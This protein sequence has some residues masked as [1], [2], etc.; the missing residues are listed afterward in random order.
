MKE[1]ILYKKHFRNIGSDVESLLIMPA[2]LRKEVFHQLH[3][4]VPGGHLGKT[5]T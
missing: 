4:N 2:V 1:D 3:D 5:K